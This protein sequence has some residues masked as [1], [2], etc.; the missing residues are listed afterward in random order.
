MILHTKCWK[1]YQ[2]RPR[3]TEREFKGEYASYME[4]FDGYLYSMKWVTFLQ[5]ELNMASKLEEVKAQAI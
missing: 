2:A 4:G 5:K 1:F 3:E